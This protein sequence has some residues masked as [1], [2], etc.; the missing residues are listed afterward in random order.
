MYPIHFFIK[1]RFQIFTY[2]PFY[3][4]AI[5]PKST[6]SSHIEQNMEIFAFTLSP[7]DM[8]T[9]DNMDKN[10]HFCWNPNEVA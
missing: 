4:P 2:E 9:L 10:T 3:F 7:E 5:L 6:N 1:L 8:I